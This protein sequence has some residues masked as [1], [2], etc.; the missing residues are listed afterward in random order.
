MMYCVFGWL[1]CIL[2]INGWEFFPNGFSSQK[3]ESSLKLHSSM[4]VR[5]K[6]KERKKKMNTK[7]LLGLGCNFWA[8]LEK[9]GEHCKLSVVW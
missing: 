5:K 3:R 8:K 9:W 6:K 1:A 2:F 4:F 7:I